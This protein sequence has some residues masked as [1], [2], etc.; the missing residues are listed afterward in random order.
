MKK[1]KMP[2][3]DL[4]TEPNDVYKV[5]GVRYIREELTQDKMTSIMER[6]AVAQEKQLAVYERTEKMMKLIIGKLPK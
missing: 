4:I 3:S 5:N 6:I 1:T 2:A